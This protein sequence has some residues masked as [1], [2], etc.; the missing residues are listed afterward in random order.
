L[1]S[2]G[3]RIS[4]EAECDLDQIVAFTTAAWGW[5]QA[6]KYLNK[7]EDCFELLAGSP[8]IGRRS[9]SILEG[10]HRFEIGSHVVFYVPELGGVLIVRVLHEQMLPAKYF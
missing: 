9:D 8:S 5:R 1:N 10:L 3:V 2:S 4:E 7:M 6:Q